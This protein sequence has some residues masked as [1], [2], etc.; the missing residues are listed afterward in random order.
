MQCQGDLQ[1][2]RCG[3]RAR[4]VACCYETDLSRSPQKLDLPR[5]RQRA[6]QHIISQLTVQNCPFEVFTNFSA[7]YEQV[8]KVSGIRVDV[9]A[10]G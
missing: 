6:F 7:T 4:Q 3:C 10:R 2:C 5:L 9:D 1:A 8:R